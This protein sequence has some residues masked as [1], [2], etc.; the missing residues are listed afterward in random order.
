[1]ISQKALV[2]HI[3]EHIQGGEREQDRLIKFR[4]DY[5]KTSMDGIRIL[6]KTDS[7]CNQSSYINTMTR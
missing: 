4:K 7:Y 5:C 2:K 1:M 6:D 3:P